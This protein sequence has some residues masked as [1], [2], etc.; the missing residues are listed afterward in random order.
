MTTTTVPL[1]RPATPKPIRLKLPV[2]APN[3]HHR[4][5]TA[6]KPTITSSRPTPSASSERKAGL[7]P[8][9]AKR[10]LAAVPRIASVR[11]NT[12]AETT[13]AGD[14]APTP[15]AARNIAQLIAEAQ[16]H[17]I[18]WLIDGVMME[19][20]VHILHGREE[21]FKTMLSIQMAD[22][23]TGGGE[24]LGRS[25]QGG[26]RVGF[27]ELE[28]KPRLFGA[29]LARFFKS[30]VPAIAIL[31][32]DFRSKVLVGVTPQLRVGI[33]SKWA[34]SEGLEVV[35][36]D[37]A[38][39]LFPAKWKTDNTEQTSAVFNEIQLLP[40]PWIIAHDRKR[41][42]NDTSLNEPT[43]NEE[44][45]GSQRFS[46]DPDVVH[47]LVRPDARA[48][49]VIFYWGKMREGEKDPPLQLY[50]DKQEFR[51]RS[52]HPYLHLLREGQR[53]ESELISE[54]AA[55]YGWAE[56]RANDYLKSLKA[57]KDAQGQ[58]VI[59]ETF[60]GHRKS[61]SLLGVPVSPPEEEFEI[62]R[63]PRSKPIPPPFPE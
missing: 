20:G 8:T 63:P 61:L 39:K 45:I 57:L 56:R 14:K 1:V 47:Q 34:K 31:P 60:N 3:K 54:A 6:K 30:S 28:Q 11:T 62:N 50:F 41:Q 44:I 25:V 43:G 21:C 53:L 59:H 22:V 49:R 37:S 18:R 13:A 2:S 55:R 48:P 5:A 10:N 38:V 27:V 58:P 12:E 33:I 36:I 9:L 42:S 16:R 24:F 7:T 32:D 46:A 17:P 23:L 4:G 29:R 35:I 40:T 19:G 26:L 51:L 52:L 15:P